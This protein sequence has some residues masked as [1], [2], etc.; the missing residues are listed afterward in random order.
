MRAI[1]SQSLFFKDRRERI[2]HSR[3]L[4]WAILSKRAKEQIP[5]PAFLPFPLYFTSYS[6]ILYNIVG[7]LS[8][9]FNV[10]VQT[11]GYQ[12]LAGGWAQAKKEEQLTTHTKDR[13]T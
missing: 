7:G 10:N 2:A 4:I 5:N 12:G 3:T 1:C 13:G 9:T 6:R 8:A 11:E